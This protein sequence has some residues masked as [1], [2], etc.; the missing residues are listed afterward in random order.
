MFQLS[1]FATE[2][3]SPVAEQYSKYSPLSL[4]TSMHI[5]AKAGIPGIGNS[6]RLFTRLCIT[7]VNLYRCHLLGMPK[8]ISGNDKSI[9][10]C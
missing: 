5:L 10:F 8:T 7:F 1:Q 3:Q 9:L 4:E 2:P 6:D